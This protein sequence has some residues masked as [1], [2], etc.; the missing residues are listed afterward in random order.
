MKIR[1]GFVVREIAGESVV[2][3]LG[4]ASQI[5][6]GMIKLNETGRVIWDGLVAGKDRDQIVDSMLLEYDVERSVLETDF[7]KFISVLRGANILE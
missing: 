6:N 2:I 1:E 7:E 5:F 4:K 3:A